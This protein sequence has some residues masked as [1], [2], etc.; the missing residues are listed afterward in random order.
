MRRWWQLFV[1]L[2]SAAVGIELVIS[3]FGGIY[4]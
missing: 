1:Q 2:F 4:E 3:V